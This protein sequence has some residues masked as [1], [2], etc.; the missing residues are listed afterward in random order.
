MLTSPMQTVP[1]SSCASARK[2]VDRLFVPLATDPF[3][4][5]CSGRK[6]W[7][8]R[9][10]GRQYTTDHVRTGRYVELR[11]G[12][13]D[14]ESALWGEIVD[15]LEA[16]SIEAFF[17]TVAWRSVLPESGSLSEAIC[18]ARK[19]LNIPEGETVPVLGFKV[20]LAAL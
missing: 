20:A 14:S 8:L 10:K 19:I 1:D 11:R 2:S 16:D 4:W 5:F 15:V 18:E 7:E 13:T 3:M 9:K 17:S 12:Y 6:K